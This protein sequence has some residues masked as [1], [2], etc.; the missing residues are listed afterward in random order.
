VLA[1]ITW[2][3]S[4]SSGLTAWLLAASAVVAGLMLS[5]RRQ[6]SRRRTGEA[7]GETT[8]AWLL[9]LH[10][11][12][13]LGSVLFTVV[14][15]GALVADNY[16]YFGW[17]ELFVPMASDW[18][19]GAVAWGIVAMLLMIVVQT[20]SWLMRFLPRR[21]WHTI[22]LG[23]FGIVAAATVHGWQA[24]ADRGTW[25][26]TAGL[27]SGLLVIVLAVVGR[28]RHLRSAGESSAV[29]GRSEQSFEAPRDTVV[30]V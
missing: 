12:M 19:P 2:Y 8:S 17:A 7:T 23:S 4:R 11:A 5:T 3:V 13:A 27:G 15:L 18:R 20:T 28:V 16:V 9:D 30:G 29:G 1:S 22:H 6:R 10:R 14:H 26:F 25:P 24:G 21:V